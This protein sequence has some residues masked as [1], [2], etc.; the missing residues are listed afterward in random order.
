M[1]INDEGYMC[2]NINENPWDGS[3]AYHPPKWVTKKYKVN[4]N[5]GLFEEVVE[6]NTCD[7]DNDKTCSDC[8]PY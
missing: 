3:L 8:L 4:T 5:T 7:H 1:Y 2:L 6:N